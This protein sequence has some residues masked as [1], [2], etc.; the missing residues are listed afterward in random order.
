MTSYLNG[1]PLAP[2]S[3]T[4]S[5]STGTAVSGWLM[6][7]ARRLRVCPD[8]LRPD[9]GAAG[10][11]GDDGATFLLRPSLSAASTLGFD[12]LRPRRR[13]A[14][15][16]DE[17][18]RSLERE[19]DLERDRERERERDRECRRCELPRSDPLRPKRAWRGEPWRDDVRRGDPRG[20]PWRDD[21][22]RGEPAAS[23]ECDGRW[24]R[25]GDNPRRGLHAKE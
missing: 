3:R 25:R 15:R 5:S 6:A 13:L 14:S 20:E 16:G 4:L 18:W 10:L 12:V 9:A 1:A 22:R 7:S 8:V 23:G 11:F 24:R 17:R 19:R 21:V 2:P